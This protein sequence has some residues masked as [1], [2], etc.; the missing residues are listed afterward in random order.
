MLTKLRDVPVG[1]QFMFIGSNNNTYEYR[2]NG[3]YSSQCS[4]LYGCDG[5]PWHCDNHDEMVDV[6]E[7]HPHPSQSLSCFI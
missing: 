3:W 6:D 1:H 7:Y 4:K 5:G 2:G